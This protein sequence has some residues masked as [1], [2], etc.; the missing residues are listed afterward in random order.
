[1]FLQFGG[2]LL[3]L[4]STVQQVQVDKNEE[5]ILVCYTL[6]L[7][8]GMDGGGKWKIKFIF[9]ELFLIFQKNS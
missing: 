7:A 9:L 2:V 1:M 4:L 3:A 5:N 8:F 6:L